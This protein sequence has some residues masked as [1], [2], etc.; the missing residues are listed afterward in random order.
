MQY[1]EQIIHQTTSAY[2]FSYLLSLVSLPSC[3]SLLRS[4]WFSSCEPSHTYTCSG[5]S[6]F[7]FSS[8]NFLT[9]GFRPSTVSPE[10]KRRDRAMVTAAA[11]A[12]GSCPTPRGLWREVKPLTEHPAFS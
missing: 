4:D 10:V 5:R 7:A 2:Q 8:T 6:S 3:C 11:L 12:A 9:A 1:N